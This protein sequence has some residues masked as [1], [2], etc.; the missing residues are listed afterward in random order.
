MKPNAI[1]VKRFEELMKKAQEVESTRRK[2]FLDEDIFEEYVDSEKYH[3]W[4]ISVMNLLL[5]VFGKQ[6]PH[7]VFFL[8]NH[9]VFKGWAAEFENCRGIFKSAKEDYEGG[10]TFKL[11]SLVAAEI[12]DD[13]M[14]QASELFKSGYKDPACVLVGV[15]LENALKDL[16]TREGIAHG[17]LDQMNAELCKADVYN[18]GMQKQITAWSHHR[19]K[20]AHGEWDEYTSE[21][22]ENMIKGVNRFIAER[23]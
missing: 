5:R 15:A 11:R 12:L 17:K 2:E 3:E 16:C 7:Y 23:L 18:L 9:G 20:A 22:V 19:N 1:V 8:T 14:E 6:S 21:D 10:Y 4:A 13:V